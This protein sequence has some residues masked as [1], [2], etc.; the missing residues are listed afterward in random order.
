MPGS[1]DSAPPNAAAPAALGD[2]KG[3]KFMIKTG[4]SRWACTLQ[5]RSAYERQKAS[6]A[7]STDSASS[8]DSVESSA[9]SAHSSH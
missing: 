5:D 8:A 9:S 1:A 3:I 2:N 4:N 7:N 6:R